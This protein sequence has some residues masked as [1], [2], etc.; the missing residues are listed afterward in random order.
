MIIQRTDTILSPAGA[1]AAR[2]DEV[3]EE[4]EEEEEARSEIKGLETLG[5][6][7]EVVVWDHERLPD[8]EGD[9]YI[10]GLREWIAVAGCVNCVE[11]D[12]DGDV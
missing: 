10:R 5:T 1:G 2:E 4:E 8:A 7:D 3:E 9:V 6:F 11:G 12:G